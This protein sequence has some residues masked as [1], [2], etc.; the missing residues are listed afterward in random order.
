VRGVAMALMKLADQGRIDIVSLRA[1][2]DSRDHREI[3]R[4]LSADTRLAL[5]LCG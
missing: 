3:V 2:L 1:E 4:L 5:S